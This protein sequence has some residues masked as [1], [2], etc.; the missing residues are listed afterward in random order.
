MNAAKRVACIA[1]RGLRV[2]SATGARRR[3]RHRA[4]GLAPLASASCQ[5]RAGDSDRAVV[6]MR[7]KASPWTGCG[8]LASANRLRR[9]GC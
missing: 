1:E 6:P 5:P 4:Q 3:R 8:P 2:A 9:S 7:N